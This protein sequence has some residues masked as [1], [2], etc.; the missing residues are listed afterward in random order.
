M[1]LLEP[2]F[3][4]KP[5]CMVALGQIQLHITLPNKKGKRATVDTWNIAQK[6]RSGLVP[7]IK[8]NEV[9]EA[10]AIKNAV[11]ATVRKLT[12]GNLSFLAGFSWVLPNM[13]RMKGIRLIIKVNVY[14]RILFSPAGFESG[15]EYDTMVMISGNSQMCAACL[16][17]QQ[18]YFI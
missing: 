14:N 8:A 6:K 2:I 17:R 11:C 1:S 10:Q 13:K 4:N 3:L 12:I 7:L 18:K 5:S 15:R 9:T 16:S